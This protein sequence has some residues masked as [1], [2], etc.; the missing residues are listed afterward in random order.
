[1]RIN[2]EEFLKQ[3]ESVMPGLSTREIIEQSSCFIFKDRTVNTF[4]DEISCSQKS[5]LKIE[6]AVPA[7]PFISILRKLSEEELDIDVN[8]ECTQLLTKGKR[9]RA[10][11]NMEHEITLPIEA[12]DKPK[13]WKDLPSDFADAIAIVQP[14][15]GK[16]ENEF[17]LTCIHITSKWVEASNRHQVCRF[18]TKM[19]IKNPTLI[20]KES[21]KHIVSLDMTEFSETKHWIHFRNSTGLILSCRYSMEDYP[22]E[23][24]TKVLKMRGEPLILPKGLK[25]AVEKAEIFSF[26]NP[27]GSNVRLDLKPGKFKIRGEGAS[28]WFSEVKK[29]KYSGIPL[30]FTIPAKLLIELVQQYNDNEC[31]VDK[32]LLKVKG[33]KFIY[34]TVLGMIE[35]KKE[36]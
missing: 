29:S 3:L 21:L 16:N 2:R 15:A 14:C 32:H 10:V 11:V 6:G 20:R 5:L 8:E 19:D 35:E 7:M 25:E 23:N 31:Q 34:M 28:G 36:D 30:Q 4:N 12:V 1:M 24:I 9:K 13:K 26:E 27:E 18:K 17:I 33:R 22:S